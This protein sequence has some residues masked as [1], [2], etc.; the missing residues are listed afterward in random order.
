VQGV[1]AETSA[2]SDAHRHALVGAC[3]AALRAALTSRGGGG[4]NNT[5][6]EGLATVEESVAVSSSSSQSEQGGGSGRGREGAILLEQLCEVVCPE[7]PEPMY[8]LMLTKSP[9]Q[10]EFIRG[11]MTKNPYASTEVGV[12]DPDPKAL[13]P[14]RPELGKSANRCAPDSLSPPIDPVTI[15]S[16]LSLRWGR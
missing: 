3:V 6:E 16:H 4:H 2:Q 5:G 14:R 7:K 12:P 13:C 10:E 9:T 1:L 11:A 15:N 8:T